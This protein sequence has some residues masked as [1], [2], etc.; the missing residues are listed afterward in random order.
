MDTK[1]PTNSLV[2]LI[3][4]AYQAEKTIKRCLD[5]LIAQTYR[6]IEILVVDDG[7][8]DGTSR[9]IADISRSDNRISCFRQGN[10]GIGSARN[11]GL[12]HAQGRYVGFVDSDDCVSPSYVSTLVSAIESQECIDLA[13]CGYTTVFADYGFQLIEPS[14][15]GIFSGEE[16]LLRMLRSYD[17]CRFLV[18]WNK[19]FRRNILSQMSFPES[20]Y[21]EDALLVEQYYLRCRTVICIPDTVYYYMHTSQGIT[22]SSQAGVYYPKDLHMNLSHLRLAINSTRYAPALKTLFIRTLDSSVLAQ[23]KNR[24]EIEDS[25]ALQNI[26]PLVYQQLSIYAKICSKIASSSPRLY[27]I[28]LTIKGRIK[29]MKKISYIRRL[30]GR[31][32]NNALPSNSAKN[33]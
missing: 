4:P 27:R 33:R 29:K 25:L 5:S 15:N 14:L 18:C 24:S 19:L 6:N 2:S 7:S 30:P 13:I 22:R 11:L 1:T 26:T 8:T 28:W 12:S 3:I 20:S 16:I 32:V 17:S 9:A 10:G 31:K 23:S 21:G